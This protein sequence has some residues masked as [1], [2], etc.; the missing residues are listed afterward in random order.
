MLLEKLK[1]TPENLFSRMWSLTLKPNTPQQILSVQAYIS[2]L[3]LEQLQDV[4]RSASIAPLGVGSF[5]FP[6]DFK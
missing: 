2:I 6:F 3:I 1:E 5:C 4:T